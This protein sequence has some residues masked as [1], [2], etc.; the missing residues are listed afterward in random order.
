MKQETTTQPT[1]T[2][3][4]TESQGSKDRDLVAMFKAGDSL[5]AIGKALDISHVT[6]RARL[7]ALGLEMRPRGAARAVNLSVVKRHIDAGKTHEE[8]ARLMNVS[9]S[10][11][12]R[13]VAALGE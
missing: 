6:A 13:A 1:S 2:Q 7:L 10:T 12:S 5:R 8:T 11:V 3:P 4:Y 9:K